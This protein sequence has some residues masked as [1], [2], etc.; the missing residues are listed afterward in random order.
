MRYN[1]SFV[2]GP[3]EIDFDRDTTSTIQADPKYYP[4]KQGWV[5]WR[6]DLTPAHNTPADK[7][8]EGAV[9]LRIS[10]NLNDEIGGI[11]MDDSV[12]LGRYRPR[13]K[14]AFGTEWDPTAYEVFDFQLWEPTDTFATYDYDNIQTTPD[15]ATTFQELTLHYVIGSKWK[16]QGGVWVS[17]FF[18]SYYVAN[19]SVILNGFISFSKPFLNF[20]WRSFFEEFA[21]SDD[22]WFDREQFQE[23]GERTPS[24]WSL[25]A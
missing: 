8:V 15:K 2:S 9:M 4:P 6:L 5:M 14:L 21:F 20:S 10:Q 19:I 16:D 1:A 18:C 12:A 7:Q 17:I 11:Y 23:L 13:I 25:V 22:Y 24:G 3:K